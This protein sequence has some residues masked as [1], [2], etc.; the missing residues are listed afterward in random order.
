MMA[1]IRLWF[2]AMQISYRELMTI[3]H[4]MGCGG[5]LLLG[6]SGVLI[7]LYRM[8]HADKSAP[9]TLFEQKL[10]RLYLV[11]MAVL[12]WAAVFS[13]A[14][15][16]YPWYRAHPA[17]DITDLSG[18]PQR[19]LLSHPE[20][21]GWHNVGME[22]KEHVAW[23]A[24]ILIT[25]VA[26]IFVK[27]RAGLSQHRQIRNATLA[28]TMAAFLAAAIAGGFGALLNK[29]APIRGGAVINLMEGGK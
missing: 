25:M 9:L 10:L 19:Y 7:Q 3:L 26:W 15:I 22:W 29:N 27:Y 17:P 6:F 20:T 21:A 2:T 11:I 14:Y 24:P 16:V 23:F 8:R 13:G 5:L 1:G 12:A 28:F 18:Y 4:G